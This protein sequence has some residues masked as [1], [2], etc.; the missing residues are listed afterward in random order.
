MLFVALSCMSVLLFAV[1]KTDKSLINPAFITLALW[2]LL[3]IAYSV[4]DLGLYGLSDNFYWILLLWNGMF[5]LGYFVVYAIPV[6]RFYH[7]H[8]EPIHF[9]YS[10]WVPVFFSIF[11]VISLLFQLKEALSLDPHNLFSAVR[12]ISLARSEGEIESVSMWRLLCG[13]I[14]SISYLICFFYQWNNIKIRNIYIFKLLVIISLL[15]TAN[16]FYLAKFVVGVVVIMG[17]KKKLKISSIIGFIIVIFTVFVIIQIMR[18]SD[19]SE[20]DFIRFI[21]SYIF[22]PLTAFDSYILQSNSL[23]SLSSTDFG[24]HTF[25]A[26][27]DTNIPPNPEYFENGNFVYVPTPTNVFTVLSAYFIDWQWAGILWAGLFFGVFFSY[28]YQRSKVQDAY[29]LLY[30]S[31]AYV[32]VLQ[33][34][35]D[36]L[37]T[38]QIWSNIKVIIILFFVFY[39]PIIY[40]KQ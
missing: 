16:K 26:L 37:I 35:F 5:S 8:R 31:L 21:C 11:L 9:L 40:D 36:F 30:A 23:M 33:F 1:R 38:R 34:F 15:F 18:K 29:K 24:G 6:N 17:Y 32:L 22:A 7:L 13:R 27:F 4:I 28:I 25:A 3:L 10:K 12:I 19:S 2:I 39:P 20:F 14:A